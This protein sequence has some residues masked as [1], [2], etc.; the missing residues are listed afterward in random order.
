MPRSPT[1]LHP[2]V[3][4]VVHPGLKP[5]SEVCVTCPDSENPVCGSPP[6][7]GK[8]PAVGL[9]L[10]LAGRPGSEPGATLRLPP[11]ATDL[12]PDNY[13]NLMDFTPISALMPQK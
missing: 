12:H 3:L 1:E 2:G 10:V 5:G 13:S 4:Y 8:L 7:P 9:P 11:S 6:P